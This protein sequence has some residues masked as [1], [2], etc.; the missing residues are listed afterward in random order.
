[1]DLETLGP[2]QLAKLTA[3]LERVD[4]RKSGAKSENI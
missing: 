2:E 1:M 3:G 4:V